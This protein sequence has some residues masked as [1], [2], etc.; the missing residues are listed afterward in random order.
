M[1]VLFACK[2]FCDWSL[3]T[4]WGAITDVGGPLAGTVFGGLNSVGAAAAFLA[5]PVMGWLMVE[6]D[7]GA[8]FFCVAAFYAVAA[9]CWF[10]IDST[11][12]FWQGKESG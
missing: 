2:F 10:G 12:R 9:V 4:V 8:L 11:C 1:V 6:D 3:S 5:G 7:W